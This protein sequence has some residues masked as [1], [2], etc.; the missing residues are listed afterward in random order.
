M[1]NPDRMAISKIEREE[2]SNTQRR[3]IFRKGHLIIFFKDTGK[4]IFAETGKCSRLFHSE[5]SGTV[6]T[7][8]VRN[9]IKFL[10]IGFLSGGFLGIKLIFYKKVVISDDNKKC[11]RIS[12]I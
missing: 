1:E 3:N 2:F 9:R 7:Y 12:Y 6:F 11:R 8:I 4:V 10:V 5:L